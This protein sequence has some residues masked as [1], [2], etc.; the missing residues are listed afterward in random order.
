MSK[1]CKLCKKEDA[2]QTG[3]HLTS[4]FIVKSQ[5]GKRDDEVGHLFSDDLKIEPSQNRKADEIKED[6]IFCYGCEK[7][8]S[9]L[10]NYFSSEITNKI[11]LER[12]KSNFS[13]VISNGKTKVISCEN[14]NSVGFHLLIYSIIWRGSIS[15]K[16]LFG[17]FRLPDSVEENI[18][19]VLDVFLPDYNNFEIKEKQKM[20]LKNIAAVPELFKFYPYTILTTESNENKTGNLIY[21][22]SEDNHPYHFIVNEFIILAFFEDGDID[23]SCQDFF[24]LDGHFSLIEA[25]NT[26]VEEVKI[27][28]LDEDK[29]EK[30]MKNYLSI[31]KQNRAKNVLT[32]CKESLLSKGITPTKKNMRECYE[33][34]TGE[35]I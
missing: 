8:L 3:S 32:E 10:E 31:V 16:R 6:F 21:F 23:F 22:S 17:K 5:L 27:G 33:D 20:W 15:N 9:F 2:N 19:E 4:C 25:L 7:R 28:L 18:R 11:G 26:D 29:W 13:E 34:K 12:Y 24:E 14:V 1:K 35:K 30:I